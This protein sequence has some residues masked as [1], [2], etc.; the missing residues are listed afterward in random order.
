ME[1]KII[2]RIGENHQNFIT[3]VAEKFNVKTS[4]I[5]RAAL[6]LL[7]GAYENKLMMDKI[8]E[9]SITTKL[10][11]ANLENEINQLQEK[12]NILQKEKET[13]IA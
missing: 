10:K 11:I 6:D 2:V 7:Q 12:I 8:E 5:V 13:L 9:S 1:A 4:V 3:Y